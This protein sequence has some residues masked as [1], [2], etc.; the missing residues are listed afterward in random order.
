M[1]KMN[2]RNSAF[3]TIYYTNTVLITPNVIVLED[4]KFGT[5]NSQRNPYCDSENR[6]FREL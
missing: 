5:W 3:I 2:A 1:M 6:N 4:I